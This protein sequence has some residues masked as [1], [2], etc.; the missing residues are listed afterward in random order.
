MRLNREVVA[1][2]QLGQR[3][4]AIFKAA[5]NRVNFLRGGR[6]LEFHYVAE[7]I[8]IAKSAGLDRIALMT[9]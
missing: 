1:V 5:A 3:L 7:V 9:E 8:D 4:T 2:E 6:E